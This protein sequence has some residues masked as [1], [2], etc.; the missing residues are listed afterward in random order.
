MADRLDIILEDTGEGVS[1][2]ALRT[3]LDRTLRTL[4]SESGDQEGVTWQITKASMNSPFSLTIERRV[5][6][7]VPEPVERPAERLV[8]SFAALRAEQKINGDMTLPVARR[9]AGIVEL[10]TA[11]GRRVVFQAARGEAIHLEPQWGGMLRSWVH[12]KVSEQTLP[13]QPYSTAGRLEGVDVHGKKSEFYVYDPLTDQKMRCLFEE[14]LLDRVAEALGRRVEVSGLTKFNAEDQPTR[15]K[16][17]HLRV[18]ESRPFLQRLKEAQRRGVMN[19]TGGLSVEDALGE[20]R[21]AQA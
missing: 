14:P 13:D 9:L 7:D 17:D 15:M 11:P 1:A 2:D 20:V 6:P 21:N 12:R 16:A 3:L 8:Q 18:I 4:R 19:L 5:Q 10:A